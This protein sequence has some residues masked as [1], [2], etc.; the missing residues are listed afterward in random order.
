ML[1]IVTAI[2]LSL[3]LAPLNPIEQ[4]TVAQANLHLTAGITTAS[5]V[6]HG[7]PELTVKYEMLAHH[8]WIIRAGF[9]YEFGSTKANLVP[10][11]TLHQATVSLVALYYRGTN[12]LTAYIGGGPMYRFGDLKLTSEAADELLATESIADVDLKADFGYQLILGLRYLRVFSL[13][14]GVSEFRTDFE[15]TRQFSPGVTSHSRERAELSNFRV[16]LGYL[17]PIIN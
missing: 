5:R 9:D 7:G 8:P 12:H 13:E 11:G 14:I 3:P 10:D 6:V 15:Y 17:I 1:S 16:T 2:W 4:D